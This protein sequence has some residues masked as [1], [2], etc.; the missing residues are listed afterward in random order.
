MLLLSL[1]IK[2]IEKSKP[3]ALEGGQASRREEVIF[4][5]RKLKEMA[6]LAETLNK[7]KR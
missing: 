5:A 2:K 1:K 6:E 3:F 7:R 4:K